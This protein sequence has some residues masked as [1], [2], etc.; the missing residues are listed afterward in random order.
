MTNDELY[1]ALMDIARDVSCIRD[2][3]EFVGQTNTPVYRRASIAT[4]KLDELIDIVE[5]MEGNQN[6]Y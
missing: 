3:C 1:E 2:M 5:E 4:D 6:E